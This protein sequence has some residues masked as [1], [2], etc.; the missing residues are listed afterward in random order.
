MSRRFTLG[1]WL[2]IGLAAMALLFTA[3]SPPPAA[4]SDAPAADAKT[5][6]DAVLRFAYANAPGTLDPHVVNTAFANVPLF[7]IFD[8][9]VHMDTAGEA[10]PGLA[11]SWEWSEDGKVLTL[12]LREGVTFH[13]GEPFNADAVK[14]NIERAKTV[15]ASFVAN[16]L[17]SIDS[18]K[19]VDDSTVELH[20][21]APD[22]GL[23]LKLSDRAGAMIS[24][25]TMT[26]DAVNLHPAGTGMYKVAEDYKVGVELRTEKFDGYWG[27]EAQ[28]L[29]GIEMTFNADT[30]A[31]LNAIRS[32]SVDAG[33]LREPEIDT[34]KSAGLQVVQG[35]DLGFGNILMNPDLTPALKDERVRMAVNLAIDR[36]SLVDGVLFGHGKVTNQPFPGGYFA[37]NDD[38]P[39]YDYDPE[40]A[41]ELLKEAGFP[42]GFT[43]PIHNVPG[44]GTRINEAVAGQL[45]KVGI[46]V[47]VLETEAAAVGAMYSVEKT[48]PALNV[49][50]TGRPDP[51]AT[52]D[53]VF[54]PGG[55]N[56]PS[57]LASKKAIELNE[58]QRAESDDAKRAELLQELSAELVEHPP[59]SN[60]VLFQSVTATGAN[61]KVVGLDAYISGKIEFRGVGMTEG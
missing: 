51:T 44:P 37:H 61:N 50:W 55:S 43:W 2:V 9:L 42:N 39:Q 48:A 40:A 31:I 8:R 33:Y 19:A 12:K 27:P 11:E 26:G 21:N 35:Y 15:E 46:K 58:Q 18:V 16:D 49:R 32:D 1:R 56:N 4:E 60:I 20:L 28:K 59:A 10:V 54:M 30:T 41:K 5:D 53:L 45:E 38:V 22:V 57:G 24:P 25:K 47:K 36:Q 3:C 17:A 7:Q 29:A 6:P 23:V 34:A 52:L 13:D 14:K